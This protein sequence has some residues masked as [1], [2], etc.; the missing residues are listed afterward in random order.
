MASTTF[1]GPIK[2]GEIK[3]TTGTTLGTNIANVGNV[4]MAQSG[5]ITQAASTGQ[6]AGV[7]LTDIVIPA[8]STIVGIELY[9]RTA[10][11]GVATTLGIGT[12]ASATALTAAAAVAGGTIGIVEASPGSD[13]TRTAAWVDVGTTDIRIL[14]TS[15]NT[16]SG[17]GTVVVTYIQNNNQL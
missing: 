8:N 9:V 16:G 4:L 14:I 13:A 12:T 5:N 6:S 10:W 17:V 1:S 11:T 3:H 7:Y 2:A 15:T